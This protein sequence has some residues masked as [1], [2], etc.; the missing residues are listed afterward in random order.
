MLQQ[1]QDPS[2]WLAFANS[3]DPA[4]T[5][6]FFCLFFWFFLVAQSLTGQHP[7]SGM[8]PEWRLQGWHSDSEITSRAIV[9][10]RLQQP[11]SGLCL[12]CWPHYPMSTLLLV[13][14]KRILGILGTASS[15]L[16]VLHFSACLAWARSLTR[17]VKSPGDFW[18]SFAF[19]I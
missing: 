1:R 11:L 12:D 10:N 6:G 7:D 17:K 19:V 3:Q 18:K 14:T 16:K 2:S 5:A 4:N 9:L 8:F 13:F 15:Q